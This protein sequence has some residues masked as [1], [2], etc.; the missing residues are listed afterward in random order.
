[1]LFLGGSDT[2]TLEY[3]SKLLGKETIRSINNSR[4]YGRQ[5]SYSMSY[6]K[7]GRELM[8]PDELR[9]MDN[10]N[11]VLFIRGLYPF[12]SKKYKLESHP[13]YSLSGDADD[14]NLFDVKS[15]FNT[16]RS[17]EMPRA[18]SRAMRIMKEAERADTRESERQVRMNSRPVQRRSAK[19]RDLGTVRAMEEEFPSLQGIRDP[20]RLTQEQ[21]IRLREETDALSLRTV[22]NRPGEVAQE[23]YEQKQMEMFDMFHSFYDIPEDQNAYGEYE[24]E[25]E[26][27]EED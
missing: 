10:N 20:D 12:F 11:C 14:D 3:F 24:A 13:N 5:G 27:G 1:M 7:T 19:G 2:T 25:P 15:T 23:N 8:T 6:N 21:K 22:V 26:R 18:Q 17:A 4:S 16:G 9:V